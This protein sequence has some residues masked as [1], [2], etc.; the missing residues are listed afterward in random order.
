MSRNRT[1][2][3][4]TRGLPPADET[5]SSLSHPVRVRDAAYR[6]GHSQI[7][8]RYRV[9]ASF[10]PVP[11]F[12]DLMGF[13][14]VAAERTVDWTLQIDVAGHPAAQRASAWP[15]YCLPR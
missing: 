14:P 10:G 13:G 12:P 6:F 5:G 4:S 7:R 1:P 3:N 8:D 11:V 15:A 2:R 9:K